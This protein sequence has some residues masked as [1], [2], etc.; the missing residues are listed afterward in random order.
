MTLTFDRSV[1]PAYPDR[2]TITLIRSMGFYPGATWAAVANL[3]T[4]ACSAQA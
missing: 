3:R 1:D 2:F 4:P